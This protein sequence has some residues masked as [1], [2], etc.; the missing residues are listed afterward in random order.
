MF[1]IN[2][3]IHLWFWCVICWWKYYSA[4]C[5]DVQMLYLFQTFN[6]KKSHCN[7]ARFVSLISDIYLKGSRTLSRTFIFLFTSLLPGVAAAIL[8]W[9]IIWQF[10]LSRRATFLLF[11][12]VYQGRIH[13]EINGISIYHT[14]WTVVDPVEGVERGETEPLKI[15]FQCVR[16][17]LKSSKLST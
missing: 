1:Y 15:P 3:L 7:S 4:T 10:H 14:N 5:N 16:L 6:L 12:K 13:S 17:C 2:K 9:G 8:A 11:L